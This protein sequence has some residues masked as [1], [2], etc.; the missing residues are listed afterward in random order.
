[1]AD[2]FFDDVGEFHR[3]FDLPVSDPE[4]PCSE[5]SMD[6]GQYRM[7]FIEEEMKELTEAFILE[8]LEGQ[9]DALLDIAWVALGTLHYLGAPG[10]EL[11]AELRRANM[12]KVRAT[13]NS[14]HKRGSH[15]VV[16]KPLGW[17]PPDIRGVIRK[18]NGG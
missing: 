6:E 16:R 12:D 13:D 7:D 1:M 11:W 9:I 14:S 3:K 2:S 18:Y 17:K 5:M 8:D 10:N 15:E 4:E